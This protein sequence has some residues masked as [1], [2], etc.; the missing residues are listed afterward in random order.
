LIFLKAINILNQEDEEDK[1][2]GDREK[3]PQMR[4]ESLQDGDMWKS[5]SAAI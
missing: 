5:K 1:A 4:P 2:K 3:K